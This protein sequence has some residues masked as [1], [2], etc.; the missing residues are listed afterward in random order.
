MNISSDSDNM[1]P[2]DSNNTYPIER[3]PGNT[4][5][6]THVR[7]SNKPRLQCCGEGNILWGVKQF[8]I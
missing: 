8:G 5:C 2:I 3:S 4:G 7:L 6:Y 1:N